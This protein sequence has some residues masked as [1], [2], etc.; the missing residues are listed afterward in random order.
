MANLFTAAIGLAVLFHSIC[1]HGQVAP[2][3]LSVNEPSK[4][5]LLRQEV[6]ALK[7]QTQS[8]T[9]ETKN[10]HASPID[11]VRIAARGDFRPA[12][13]LPSTDV[14]L[15]IGGYARADVFYDTGFV[16]IGI[17]LF[18]SAFA[19]D[20][21]P[22]AAL[23]GQT[24]IT[25][26][27]SRLSFDAQSSTKIGRTRGFAELVFLRNDPDLRL[28]HA[29]GEW[30]TTNFDLM[31]GQTWST[32]MDPR[33][34]PFAVPETSA[35]GAIFRRQGLLRIERQQ[36]EATSLS[37][38]LGA[39]TTSEPNSLCNFTRCRHS[40]SSKSANTGQGIRFL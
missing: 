39:R 34:L 24:T 30:K 38:V 16:A 33:T 12:I 26:S 8:R 4:I 15:R 6:V 40:A 5:E 37:G 10:L 29:S 20:G 19:F 9:V 2:A 25:G 31:G 23:R 3:P 27:Q 14:S 17:H 1:I 11:P 28:R 35:V 22:F 36:N 13:L 21:S 18:P 7:Q 32:F